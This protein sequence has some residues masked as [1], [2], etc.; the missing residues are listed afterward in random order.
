MSTKLS[1]RDLTSHKIQVNQVQFNVPGQ[2]EDV[3]RDVSPNFAAD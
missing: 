1:G 2:S 3:L